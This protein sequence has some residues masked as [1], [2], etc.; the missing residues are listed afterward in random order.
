[1]CLCYLLLG[2]YNYMHAG[3]QHVR[4]A[5]AEDIDK[6]HQQKFVSRSSVVKDVKVDR[7]DNCFINENVED[8]DPTNSAARKYRLIGSI[9]VMLAGLLL[10]AFSLR[11]RPNPKPYSYLLSN[12]Y[13]TQRVLR[14]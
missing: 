9:Y 2:G 13:I 11:R 14:I 6:S 10:I 5:I 7:A 3:V 4:Y 1:M 12:K 8:E